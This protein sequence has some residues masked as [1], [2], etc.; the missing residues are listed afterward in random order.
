MPGK[1]RLDHG[2]ATSQT[3][4]LLS[5]DTSSFGSEREELV[6]E[7]MSQDAADAA[8]KRVFGNRATSEELFY[9]RTRWLWLDHLWNDVRFSLR[10]LMRTMGFT[11]A[12]V[13][14]LSLAIGAG[15]AI[16]AIADEALFRPLPLPDAG[17][18]TAVYNYDQSTATYLDSSYP[19]IST[20]EITR[21]RLSDYP[22]MSGFL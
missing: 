4:G 19:T 11:T 20:I 6:E 8:A 12:V 9:E 18:L 15:T 7:G 17:Q 22:R 14:M 2:A 16:F 3:T 5:G 1:P 13:V 21:N 10:G